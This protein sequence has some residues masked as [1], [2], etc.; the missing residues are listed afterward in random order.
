MTRTTR[1]TTVPVRL[2][3]AG[4]TAA[5]AVAA[6][7]CQTGGSREPTMEQRALGVQPVSVSPAWRRFAVDN[8]RGVV[9][10][11]L[12]AQPDVRF[13]SDPDISATRRLDNGAI[14][15]N[16]IGDI[17]LNDVRGNRLRRTY[18]VSWQ[19]QGGGWD[20]GTAS[21]GEGRASPQPLLG[22]PAT[23]PAGTPSTR[24]LTPADPTA[25]L[26]GAG[27]APPA[28]LGG[29]PLP[30]TGGGTLL[31]SGGTGSP[32]LPPSGTTPP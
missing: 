17:D 11:E 14:T 20:T 27:G 16:A 6:G 13:T 32:A 31:P 15:L 2:L 4:L 26:P 18:A 30:G 23:G 29:P 9:T 8:Y 10:A 5:A 22:A 3:A 24:A 7:G 25:P 28:G 21:I 19:Q 1:P 12:R